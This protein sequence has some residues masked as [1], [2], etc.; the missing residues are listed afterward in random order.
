MADIKPILHEILLPWQR[1]WVE[2][3]SRFK[4]GM[5]SRQTG[6]SFSTSA[7]AVTDCA[8][9]PKNS[10]CLWVVLSAGERQALE[11]MEKAKKWAEA[12]KLTVDSYEELRSSA[13]SL[14]AQANIKFANGARIIA[15]PAN[16]NTAR[17]YSGNLVLDEFA[18]HDKPAEIWAAIYAS[19]T[20]PLAGEKKLRIVSTPKGRGNMFAELWDHNSNYSKHKVTILDAAREGLFGSDMKVAMEKVEELKAGLND[21][22]IFAQEYMCEFIDSTSVLLPYE[23]IGA[24]ESSNIVDDGASPKFIGMDIGRH[25]DLSVI[26]EGVKLGDVLA[27]TKIDVLKKM[28]FSDQLKIIVDKG[29]ESRVRGIAIDATGIGAMLAEEATKMLG[30]KCEG[31]QFTAA[32]KGEMYGK[33][34]RKFEERSTRVPIDR[35]LREDLHAVQRV[36]SASG[37]ITYAAPRNADGHSDRAS[38]LALCFHA[39]ERGGSYVKPFTTRRAH[40]Y[41]FRRI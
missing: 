30:S 34:R 40:S 17:G 39:A 29:R 37:N 19:I 31:V 13:N 20:N 9:Q 27:V 18:I 36:V 10:S 6:K 2:D 26:I 28:A 11:W 14:I 24:C 32:S 22:D 41:D 4:I 16:P 7:E 3:N 8:I 33:M 1:R 12:V 23:L 21:E 15:L 35:L 5:W 38:A 25:K